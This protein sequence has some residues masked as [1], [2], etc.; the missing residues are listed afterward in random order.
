MTTPPTIS[1][2]ATVTA[3]RRML[4]PVRS[5]ALWTVSGLAVQA[6]GLGVVAAFL[7]AKLRHQDLGGHV[8]AATFR[9]MWHQEV[10]THTGLAVLITGA[11]IYAAGSVL[12]ARPH[13]SRPVTLF[14]AVPVAAVAGMA[15]LGVLALVVAFVIIALGDLLAP[16]VGM[17]GYGGGG[18][19]R[20]RRRSR[21]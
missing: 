18:R 20:R 15:V 8:T 16:D 7:W 14:I 2:G 19:R 3:G 6:A 1:D 5:R 4:T 21:S 10:H 12:L 11:V 13:V 17:G 9:L